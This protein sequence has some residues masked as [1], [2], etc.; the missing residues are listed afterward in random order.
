MMTNDVELFNKRFVHFMWDES[1]VG[2]EGF[3][4]DSVGGL[5]VAA[6]G[7]SG[8][9]GMVMRESAEFNLEFVSANGSNWKFFYYDPLYDYKWNYHKGRK[10]QCKLPISGWTDIGIGG[11]HVW[12][13]NC[14]YRVVIEEDKERPLRLTWKQL[15]RWLI[16][17]NG[18][19]VS[20]HR[21][22]VF[23]TISYEE[24][25]ENCE[26]PEGWQVRKWNDDEWHEPTTDYCFPEILDKVP[27]NAAGG[28]GG[29]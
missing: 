16:M 15:A 3:F 25:Q 7:N 23:S 24:K 29:N 5:I 8:V 2:K 4:S 12:D 11:E 20:E 27:D 21:H 14:E 6:K 22:L 18:Q 19:A 9:K 28:C 17:G 13:Y 1:L 26:L 10:V